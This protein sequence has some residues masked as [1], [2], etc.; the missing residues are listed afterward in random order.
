MPRRPSTQTPAQPPI[1]ASAT[2]DHWA[3]VL[4]GFDSEKVASP[5][6]DSQ[7][8]AEFELDFE[9]SLAR[10]LGPFL[11]ALPATALTAENILRKVPVGAKGAYYLLLDGKLVYIGKSD[12]RIG[13]QARLLRH[14]K[15]LK[16]RR[17]IVWDQM[18]FKA[19][20][21]ASFAALDTESLLLDL[22]HRK[23]EV[24]GLSKAEC[25]PEWNFSGFG[26]ND[27]GRER[28]TQKVSLFDRKYPIDLS[29]VV[30]LDLDRPGPEPI[31]LTKYLDWLGKQ[32]QF[33]LRYQKKGMPP[34]R[35]LKTVNVDA[36][37]LTQDA[38]IQ[39]LLQAVIARLPEDWVLTVLRG[40]V[41]LY[42]KDNKAYKSPLWQVQA[43]LTAAT[44]PAPNYDLL[45]ADGEDVDEADG[46]PD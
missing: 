37:E 44:A 29:A 35:Q 4:N 15:T 14:Y 38:T 43:G 21:V 28:D 23:G 19:V 46:E 25:K 40:K 30:D 34:N 17:G 45:P 32:L 22:Y 20:K 18:T 6:T 13:L 1:E 24:A 8:Y 7:G 9:S 42:Y 33:T 26:S 10:Q 27:P 2:Q 39:G 41:L 3:A 5:P 12:A 36:A 31:P 16:R 11:D